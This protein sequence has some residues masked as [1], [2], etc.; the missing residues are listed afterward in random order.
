MHR[1]SNAEQNSWGRPKHKPRACS[2]EP[3]LL[4]LQA[5]RQATACAGEP[6]KGP[7]TMQVG[8]RRDVIFV[9]LREKK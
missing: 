6:Q 5:P 7:G 2:D 1:Q 9:D 4:H 3:D 8:S